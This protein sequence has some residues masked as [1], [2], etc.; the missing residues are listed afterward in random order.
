VTDPDACPLVQRADIVISDR[1]PTEQDT[2]LSTM[3]GI[4][5]TK[6]ANADAKP[7]I[8]GN[9]SVSLV[10]LLDVISSTRSH[11]SAK[12]FMGS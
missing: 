4:S 3:N 11:H 2:F 5:L 7:E 10:R 12:M 9:L 6:A 1:C 8:V